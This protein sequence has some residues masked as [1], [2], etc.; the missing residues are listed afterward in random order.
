M[1]SKKFR[2]LHLKLW[3][4]VSSIVF[5]QEGYVREQS[6]KVSV[7]YLFIEERRL[8]NLVQNLKQG[9]GQELLLKLYWK[10]LENRRVW[11]LLLEYQPVPIRV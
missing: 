4:K 1:K 6:L 10:I 8:N 3:P 9:L 11:N 2:L 5:M 7:K